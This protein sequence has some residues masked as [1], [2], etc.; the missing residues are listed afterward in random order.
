MKTLTRKIA[1]KSNEANCW[2]LNSGLRLTMHLTKFAGYKSTWYND[3]QLKASWS[4]D[5]RSH[6]EI[7]SNDWM[8][9]WHRQIH[10]HAQITFD[11]GAGHIHWFRNEMNLW[12]KDERYMKSHS[13]EHWTLFGVLSCFFVVFFFCCCLLILKESKIKVINFWPLFRCN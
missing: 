9:A 1:N 10:T 11:C 5:C 13:V 12:V 2:T 4:I 8:M 7:N 6:C 3:I